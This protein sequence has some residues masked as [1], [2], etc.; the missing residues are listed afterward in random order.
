MK[1]ELKIGNFKL[2]EEL[3]KAT[4]ISYQDINDIILET[5]ITKLIKDNKYDLKQIK[6]YFKDIFKKDYARTTRYRKLKE[7]ELIYNKIKLEY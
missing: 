1:N 3:E 5:F 2:S 4:K 7:I 6:Q